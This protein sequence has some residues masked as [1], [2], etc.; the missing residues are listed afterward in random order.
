[1]RFAQDA[2]QRGGS[3]YT[4]YEYD[5]Q[6]RLIGKGPHT[7]TGGMSQSFADQD[8]YTGGTKA[9]KIG[10][11]YDDL[12]TFQA[13]TSLTLSSIM[14][15]TYPYKSQ[16][17]ASSHGFGRMICKY[18]RNTDTP[19][20]GFGNADKFIAE[21]FLYDR[22]GNIERNYKYFG[23]V[24]TVNQKYQ[25]AAYDYDRQTGRMATETVYSS[26]LSGSV[27]MNYTYEY[28]EKGRVKKIKTEYGNTAFLEFSYMGWGPL[29]AMILGGDGSGTKGTK[30]EYSYHTSGGIQEI[31]STQLGTGKILF[32]QFLGYDGK[33]INDPKVPLNTARYTGTITQQL[34]K[35]ADDVNSLRPVRV[36]NYNFDELGRMQSADYQHNSE[37]TPTKAD[38]SIDFS[39]FY[40]QNYGDNDSYMAYDLNGRITSQA[41]G[42][43]TPA[44][45][46]NYLANSYKLNTITGKVNPSSTRN[47]TKNFVY[48]SRGAMT[49]DNT[50]DL[51]I[52]YDWNLMPTKFKMHS[53]TSPAYYYEQYCF[54]DADGQRVNSI[55]LRVS[56]GIAS[57]ESSK[58]YL[59]LGSRPYKE[60][61]EQYSGTGMTVNSTWETTNLL[62][63]SVV[64]R[65]D[66][67]GTEYYLKNHLGSM[68]MTVDEN[69]NEPSWGRVVNDYLA[70]GDKRTL[71]TGANYSITQT[72]TGKEY[73]DLY[74][75]Y[76][77]GARYYDAELGVWGTPDPANQ[78]MNPYGYGKNPAQMVDPDGEWLHIAIGAVVGAAVGVYTSV[79]AG[80][81]ILSVSTLAYAGAGAA[82]G[83]ATAATAG[84][85]GPLITG[86]VGSGAIGLGASAGVAGFAGTVAS[87]AA[88][89]AI[90]GAV[91]YSATVSVGLGTGDMK[92]LTAGQFW[93]GFAVSSLSGAAF[94]G[95]SSGVSFLSSGVRDAAQQNINSFQ[96]RFQV[97][98][99]SPASVT[100][101]RLDAQVQR[102][103]GQ[104]LVLRGGQNTA[105]RFTNGTGSYLDKYGRLH[106][107][108]VTSGPGATLEELSK[109]IRNNQVGVTTINQIEALG[110][111][112]T[113]TPSAAIPL[114]CTL[115]GITP[116]EAESLFSPTF[117]NPIKR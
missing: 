113:P 43:Q 88:I 47:M 25:E 42:G 40:F 91:S 29:K 93:E 99:Y 11:I 8:I 84:L 18:N 108:S 117:L 41:S 85:A 73:E 63:S 78:L 28:D 81:P 61:I 71:K 13:R 5:S 12:S 24:R 36:V 44:A 45:T 77:F 72:Y 32:Q 89:G 100:Q 74:G 110:G 37:G 53:V 16:F 87:G 57:W 35:F 15:D 67:S 103:R 68:M 106:D 66:I 48:D 64:G 115:C 34:Y 101:Q 50:K 97:G 38:G 58:H 105:D 52:G 51:F 104:Q 96:S 70:Y 21:F 76:Y 14:P 92:H 39:Q 79:K 31:R 6:G 17:L 102:I 95:A 1:V 49:S 10:Y 3:V 82:S 55:Q 30:V 75:L 19:L 7:I 90:G 23:P 98:P 112:V 46:Y 9:E 59:T 111:T 86:A 4:Y 20:P 116:E 62:G 26:A 83:A 80:H 27:S 60:F 114:H 94:G 33:A 65:K 22:S 69:G 109:G 56:S 107:V 54:Y 2:G